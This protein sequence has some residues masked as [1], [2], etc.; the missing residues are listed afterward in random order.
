MEFADAYYLLL[1]NTSRKVRCLP[2]RWGS[3]LPASLFVGLFF[4]LPQN[5][6][7]FFYISMCV[8][9]SNPLRDASGS[10]GRPAVFVNSEYRYS[11]IFFSSTALL[12]QA[13]PLTRSYWI[14]QSFSQKKNHFTSSQ[15]DRQRQR[16][17]TPPPLSVG[18]KNLC[19]NHLPVTYSLLVFPAL[20]S[21]G[22][23][24]IKILYKKIMCK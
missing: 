19:E 7:N 23:Y 18:N 16:R 9:G 21:D 11:G 15:T 17:L 1:L 4:I 22:C 14:K 2:Q 20:N 6:E 10:F 3:L 13:T 12:Y 24:R 8:Y 5:E